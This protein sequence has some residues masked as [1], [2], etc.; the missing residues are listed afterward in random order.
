MKPRSK[1]RKRTIWIIIILI[2]LAIWGIHR[3]GSL[4]SRLRGAWNKVIYTSNDN[5][6]ISVYSP[7]TRHIY[8]ATNAPGH[9]FHTASTVKVT[10]LAGLLVKQPNGLTSHQYDLAKAMIEQSD[11]TPTTLLFNDLGKQQGLQKAFD[12]FG[13]SD[14]VARKNWGLSTTTPRDQVKLL[15]NIFYKSKLLSSQD[16]NLIGGLM[17]NVDADQ[18]WGISADSNH[19]AIKNGW[20]DY[21]SSKWMVNS[22]GYV[23]NSNG[24]D[25]TIAIYTDKNS[26]MQTGQ[27]TIEQL[28]RVTKSLMQ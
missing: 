21:G 28:A 16:Q 17:S 5:V 27:Q 23:K 13:M 10:I 19:F 2:V 20:L 14:S 3:Y 8:S 4:G 6:A 26:T 22:I 12:E 18:S 1:R 24:T 15:N 9:K 11:N 25:Y 7:R